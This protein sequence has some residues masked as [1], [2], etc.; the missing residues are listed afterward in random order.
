MMRR[1]VSV[2]DTVPA[3]FTD[4]HNISGSGTLS[5]NEI[6]WSGLS[7]IEWSECDLDV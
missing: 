1:G 7:N 2:V 6:T 4:V 3:G 5:G